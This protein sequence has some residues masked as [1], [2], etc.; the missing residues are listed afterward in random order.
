MVDSGTRGADDGAAA[1]MRTGAAAGTGAL[2]LRPEGEEGAADRRP[3]AA[4]A[5]GAGDTRPAEDSTDDDTGSGDSARGEEA[6]EADADEQLLGEDAGVGRH[7]VAPGPRPG[8]GPGEVPVPPRRAASSSQI[9]SPVVWLLHRLAWPGHPAWA[10]RRVWL[11]CSARPQVASG[12]AARLAAAL[13]DRG[14]W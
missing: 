12:T 4:G 14:A 9:S 13:R 8:R 6:E 2:P 3:Q 7:A 10:G 11:G 5:R 1:G